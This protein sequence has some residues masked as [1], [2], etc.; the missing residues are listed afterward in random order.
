MCQALGWVISIFFRHCVNQWIDRK[1]ES[2]ERE[3]SLSVMQ[4]TGFRFLFF[5]ERG[6]LGGTE[7]SPL[8]EYRTNPLP[9]LYQSE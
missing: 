3:N 2:I 5:V 6:N 4:K 7:V 9:N 8:P 1:G